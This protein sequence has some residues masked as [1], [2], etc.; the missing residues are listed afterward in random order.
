MPLPSFGRS[1]SSNKAA[2]PERRQERPAP[3]AGEP[4]ADDAELS[5]YLAALAP[6]S[7]LESTGSGRRFGEAQVFQMRFS[8]AASQ[9]LKELAARLG[10]SPQALAQEWVLERLAEE[11]GSGPARP[12]PAARNL[13]QS[14][15][16]PQAGDFPQG[17]SLTGADDF[18]HN[19]DSPHNQDFPQGQDFPQVGQP[20][21]AATEELF[22][23][24]HQWP[25]EPVPGRHG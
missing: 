4:Q 11:S 20:T 18:P 10:T 14:Q 6:Q 19:Q 5:S 12:G 23:D 7:D 13:P 21:E 22:L 25:G 3:A 9:Q 17:G 8:L 1:R 15:H 24:Q 16:F 2:N